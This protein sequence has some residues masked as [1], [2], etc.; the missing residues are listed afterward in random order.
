MYFNVSLST[1]HS[2]DSNIS[3]GANNSLTSNILM[4]SNENPV[5]SEFVQYRQGIYNSEDYYIKKASHL[6]MEKPFILLHV[7]LALFNLDAIQYDHNNHLILFYAYQL[8]IV[9][10]LAL[11]SD[12]MV[13]FG[14]F[15]LYAIFSSQFRRGF[16]NRFLKRK[17]RSSP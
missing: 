7:T 12:S 8:H 14:H 5:V 16:A 2:M 15:Y 1:N 6:K 13:H 4:W 11:L 17:I 10:K 3:I 9:L